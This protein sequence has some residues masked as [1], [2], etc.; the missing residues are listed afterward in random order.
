VAKLDS[1]S[2]LRCRSRRYF[3]SGTRFV[4]SR[5]FISRTW[6]CAAI[7]TLRPTTLAAEP[8][9]WLVMLAAVLMLW[10]AAVVRADDGHDAWLRYAQLSGAER[11]KYDALPASVNV[12]GDSA[13]N[14]S[15]Q[16]ASG[17]NDSG[18]GRSAVND[19]SQD[20][21]VLLKSAQGELIRGVRGMLGRTLRAESGLP[22]EKSIVLTTIA[23]LRAEAPAIEAPKSLAPGSYWIAHA[24]LHG[25]DCLIVAGA[26]GRGALYGTFDLLRRIALGDDL[27]H[28]R[29]TEQPSASV[30]WVN[31][32]D[33]LNGSIERGY[34]GR[35]IFFD[36]GGARADLSRASDYARLLASVGIDGCVVNNVNAS[37]SML[38]ADFV[39]QLARIAD[40]FRP[41]GVKLAISVDFST[42]KA[43][44]QLDT[45]DPVDPRVISWWNAKVD[46][47]YKQI[48]DFGGFLVKADSEGKPGPSSYGRT[49][50]DAANMLARALAP[51][52]GVLLYRAFVYN[53]HLDWRNPKNDRAK[54]AYDIFHPLDGKFAENVIIQIKNG[55]IDFQVREPASPLF[56]GLQKT[57]EAI[58]LQITQEYT[59]QQRH[60]V[61]LAPM[62]K[63]TLDFD[64][65]VNGRST[66][67][68]NIVTG[69]SFGRPLGGFAGVSNVGL[70]SNWLGNPMA[71]ANLYGFGRLAW[72]PNLSAAAIGDEWTRLTFGS[73]PLV[74]RTIDAMQL[75]SWRTYED[76]TGPLGAGT[77]T[78]ILGSHYGPGVGSSEHNGWGQWHRADH[79]GVGMDRTV[80]T[81]TGYVGQYSPEVQKEFETLA[82]MPDSLLLFFHHVPYTYKLHSG[83][84][85]IQYIYDSHYE[86]VERVK[87]YVRDW[88]SLRGRIDDERYAFVLGRLEYQVGH[89]IVWRDAVCNWFCR[90]SGIPDARG[91][92]G[93]YPD[94][95][96]AESM[97]LQ[98]YAPVDVTP[99]E[100]A[101]GGK[102]V[103]CAAPNETCVASFSFK[104]PAGWYEL[105]V[106]YF[107]LSNGNAT[108][109]VFVGKQLVDE[110]VADDELPNAQIGGDTSTRRA[111]P[112]LA[113]RAGDIVRIEGTPDGGEPAPFDY[114]SIHASQN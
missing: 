94:R 65:R 87:Q 49:P 92:V 7:S 52:G 80:A 19:S 90:V 11:A 21:A 105:D 22:T 78:N 101:S 57:N 35:S 51:H 3:I 34:G 76:Y 89:A 69:R 66:P 56:G 63:A 48:P 36:N 61:F 47:I 88:E 1:I 75:S 13:S 17:S 31:E 46:D 60:L 106:Q 86:G 27:T 43:L 39:P 25:F 40:A 58:E 23:E 18:A 72:N 107:D 16:D 73:D 32:W 99:P 55:P 103:E 91:R 100:N 109:R 5:R 64:M 20:D 111:I 84:T 37:P 29:V 9:R 104:R 59:G 12:L 70:D 8:I 62:W 42:P 85:V 68:K 15:T 67:V 45:F 14:T 108:F 112:G 77:L 74:D 53:M 50:A 26:D 82:A 95:V 79:D 98:G 28:P 4:S 38:R 41:W 10:P 113:L 44:G 2:R 71:M 83:Q 6:W 102:A 81:G 24:S 96:E 33:N 30:R 93:H 97:E 114:V 110:W 54:A